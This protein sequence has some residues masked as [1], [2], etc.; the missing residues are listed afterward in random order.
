MSDKDRAEILGEYDNEMIIRDRWGAAINIGRE[1]WTRIA[2]GMLEKAG[3][4]IE[5]KPGKDI[6]PKL[7]CA[8]ANPGDTVVVIRGEK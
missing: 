5:V 1:D 7:H 8:S 3:A 6:I 2:L 4:E